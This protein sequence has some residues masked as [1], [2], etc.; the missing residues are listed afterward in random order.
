MHNGVFTSAPRDLIKERVRKGEIRVLIGTDAASEGLNLQR[1]G[2]LINL[3]LPWNPSRL[4][5]RKGRIQRIGQLREKGGPPWRTC[6]LYPA[7]RSGRELEGGAAPGPRLAFRSVAGEHCEPGAGGG[8][9]GVAQ[10]HLEDLWIDF[11]LREVDAAKIGTHDGTTA[12]APTGCLTHDR[13]G[14]ALEAGQV[15]RAQLAVGRDNR[16]QSCRTQEPASDPRGD[17]AG[18][19][20]ALP[21]AEDRRYRRTR[22]ELAGLLVTMAD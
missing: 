19:T 8:G 12:L 4:E 5:Q 7:L 11:A 18:A 2:T 16:R 15:H 6:G 21:G 10:K 13:T 1:L 3:D 22:D 14:Q 9:G 20:I 17:W